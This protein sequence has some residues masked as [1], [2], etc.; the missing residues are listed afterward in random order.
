MYVI[1]TSFNVKYLFLFYRYL[2]KIQTPSN[3][4]MIAR[5]ERWGGVVKWRGAWTGRSDSRSGRGGERRRELRLA[6]TA[7]PKLQL[8]PA[9]SQLTLLLHGH[10]PF[11]SIDFPLVFFFRSKTL[12][13]N[14]K[15]PRA[16]RDAASSLPRLHVS[17]PATP[18]NLP[19]FHHQLPTNHSPLRAFAYSDTHLA[20]V[21]AAASS[22]FF[23]ENGFGDHYHLLP[24]HNHILVIL[25]PSYSFLVYVL[26]PMR[27]LNNIPGDITYIY[28]IEICYSVYIMFSANNCY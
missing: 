13:R 8:S 17:L 24:A 27:R 19:R 5:L 28:K 11:D 7:V 2:Q 20:K 26:C 23:W 25:V 4:W 1:T 21:G 6:C 22:I 12:P 18:P 3:C 15:P 14:L 10:A 9:H 16:P